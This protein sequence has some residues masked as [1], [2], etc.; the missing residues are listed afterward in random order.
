VRRHV[1]PRYQQLSRTSAY[2]RECVGSRFDWTSAATTFEPATH[3]KAAATKYFSQIE[4]LKRSPPRGEPVLLKAIQDYFHRCGIKCSED[5]I[6]IAPSTF[7]IVGDI[8]DLTKPAGKVL[9][10]G[11]EDK[12]VTLNGVGK[13]RGL[14]SMFVSFCTAPRNIEDALRNTFLFLQFIHV[15]PFS[16]S[17]PAR[18]RR[19]AGRASGSR[20]I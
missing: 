7:Q 9:L 10:E 17:S 8:F 2:L 5:N 14:P 13:S 15:H 3:I 6:L 18:P 19:A 12:V 16:L 1:A 11:I 4:S 20:P